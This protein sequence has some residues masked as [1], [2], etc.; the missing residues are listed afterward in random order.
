MSDTQQVVDN[1]L[2]NEW[3]QL[4]QNEKKK[5]LQIGTQTMKGFGTDKFPKDKERVSWGRVF[6]TDIRIN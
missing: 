3:I 5:K 6:W 4:C 1:Y 2:L